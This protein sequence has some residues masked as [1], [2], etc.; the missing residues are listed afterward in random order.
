MEASAKEGINT[1]KIFIKAA[2]TLL[3]DYIKYE[4]NIKDEGEKPQNNVENVQNTNLQQ[5]PDTTKIDNQP[6]EKS[7]KC[8]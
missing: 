6:K 5:N 4:K 3:D 2:K 7:K 8:C 1:Q